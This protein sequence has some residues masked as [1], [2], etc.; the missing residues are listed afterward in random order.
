MSSGAA[1]PA[2]ERPFEDDDWALLISDIEQRN[3]VPVIG[4]GLLIRGTDRAFTLHQ[5]L[6]IELVKQFR[7]DTSRL[8]AK[9]TLLD[10]C[11]QI[12]DRRRIC[13]ALRKALQSTDWPLPEPLVQ[14][15]AIS[16]FDL[17]VSTTFDSLL[18][19][20]VRQARVTA[21]ER[22]YGLKRPVEDIPSDRLLAPLVFQIFGRMDG[23]AD[24]ALSEEEILEFIQKLL[25]EDYRPQRIF[26]LFARRNLLFLG[27][28]FPGWLGRLIRRVLKVS[29]DL[30]DSGL[31]AEECCSADPTYMLFLERQ[32]AKLWLK[33]AGIDFADELYR[34]WRQRHPLGESP[35]VF[36]SY[37]R[38][39][40]DIAVKLSALFEKS[41]VRVWFDRNQLR[42][43]EKWGKEIQDAVQ[44][45]LVFVPVISRHSTRAESRFCQ[46]EWEM[47]AGM[48]IKQIC[49]LLTDF[50]VIPKEFEASHARKLAEVEDLV[51]D[52][53]QFLDQR[54]ARHARE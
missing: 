3:V 27:C 22:I 14:L 9:P 12:P 40:E 6:A 53:K 39:D 8:Q 33:D 50:T 15:A 26:D 49:P 46:Q 42:S 24:S 10:I 7:L 16:D 51:R 23:A 11:S 5:H 31:F 34:R 54:E 47:A 29:G 2:T 20:A 45:C 1:T 21:E 52:V 43:G 19:H 17:Y 41:G 36:I 18:F 30:R 35:S 13:D 44:S 37:A 28:D 32:G 38:E 25:K 4:P 48:E